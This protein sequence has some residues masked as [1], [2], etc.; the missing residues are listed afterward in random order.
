MLKKDL[1]LIQSFCIQILL[2]KSYKLFKL[3]K[4][5]R[6]SMNQLRILF[7]TCG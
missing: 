6:K 3:R 5:K 2:A 1:H 4:Y 7:I